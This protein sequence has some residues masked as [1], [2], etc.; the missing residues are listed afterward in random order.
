MYQ[1]LYVEFN[2]SGNIFLEF[3]IYGFKPKFYLSENNIKL[4]KNPLLKNSKIKD[5]KK[6][7]KKLTISDRFCLINLKN[8]ES[9]F[10][11]PLVFF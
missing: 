1:K 11:L 5:L 7:I 6:I 10:H 3:E 9:N 8:I 2:L 4:K